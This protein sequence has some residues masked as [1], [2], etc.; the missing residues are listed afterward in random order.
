MTDPGRSSFP[1]SPTRHPGGASSEPALTADDIVAATGGRLIRRSDRPVRFAAVDSRLVTPGSLFV[2]LAGER[3]DGHRY[4]AA[5]RDAG[6]SAFLVAR[7][8]E[9]GEPPL[10]ALGDA[11]VVLVPDALRGLHA[12]AAAWRRRFDP[13]VVGITGSIAKTSTKEAVAGVL[14]GRYETL[15][16]EG[17]QNNEV[18]M[19]LTVLRLGPEHGAVVL[20][21][22][23]Y[24]GGEIRDLAAIGLPRI[25]IVTAVQPV[26]LSRIGSIE[27]IEDAK[28]ELVEAL[29][30]AGDGGIAI[31]NA[32]DERVRRMAA[33]T[34]ARATTYGFADEADVR[35]ADV[36]SLG[37]DGMRFRLVSP[38]GQRTVTIPALGRLAVHNALAATA[39]GLA[40]GMTL[41]EIVPG[42]SAGSTA[43]HRSVVIRLGGVV[44]VDDSYNASPGSVRAALELLAGIPGRHVA[45]LGPMRELG[46]AHEA[47]HEE[48]GRAAGSTLHRLVVVDG[49]PGGEAEGIVRGARAV[50][51]DDARIHVVPDADAA[52]EAVAATLAP[53]DVVLVKASRGVEL[54]RVVEGLVTRLG[55]PGGPG[56]GVRP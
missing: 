46:D 1:D 27:A 49:G 4:L 10:E 43:P 12:V 48:V 52:V 42:L 14:A 40:A 31:L 28:A 54:E 47:G 29:P 33:R 19:P 15:R 51:M 21:M 36:I 13:I 56:A 11:T 30:S 20:E 16:T 44:I 53:G 34:P 32:D 23:M 22:G 45:V 37:L 25:G 2:A 41:D 3:T 18:G 39:A 8:P 17:N 38:A 55:G 5:A 24:T 50:A 9:P 35:A 7:T 6:A 26:H